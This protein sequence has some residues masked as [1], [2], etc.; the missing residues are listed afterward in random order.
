LDP[1]LSPIPIF[2]TNLKI[3]AKKKS[4]KTFHQKKKKKSSNTSSTFKKMMDPK[5]PKMNSIHSE[6]APVQEPRIVDEKTWLEERRA[7]L[8][9][10]K[11]LVRAY[12]ALLVQ[13]RKLSWQAIAK[14][15]TF[16]TVDGHDVKLS[17]LVPDNKD[18]KSRA[19]ILQHFMWPKGW[20]NGCS[21]CHHQRTFRC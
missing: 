20:D 8:A 6:D 15:Y 13:R 5:N 3:L 18:G 2:R 16:Q 17:G 9:A 7:L 1:Q 21:Q 11:D 12:D 19:L 10:E 4:F 14:D